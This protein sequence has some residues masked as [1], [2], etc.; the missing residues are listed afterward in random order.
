MKK[1]DLGALKQT[2]Q[3]G[4]GYGDRRPLFNTRMSAVAN[5]LS[6][7]SSTITEKAWAYLET[8]EMLALKAKGKE[9]R[10]LKRF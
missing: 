6:Q 9:I 5:L 8:E 7:S 3:I 1:L 10:D 2:Y 4:V